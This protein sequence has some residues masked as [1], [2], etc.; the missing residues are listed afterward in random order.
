M[1]VFIFRI[2]GALEPWLSTLSDAI[3]KLYPLPDGTP[4]APISTVPLPRV[5][6]QRDEEPNK[7]EPER[8]PGSISATVTVNTR[9]TAQDWFQDVRHLEFQL[10]EDVE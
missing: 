3:L 1:T 9:T 4:T 8:L 7:P 6:L 10:D 2:D 5:V